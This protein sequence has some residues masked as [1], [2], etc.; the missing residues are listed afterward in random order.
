MHG[1]AVLHVAQSF[2]LRPQRDVH[3]DHWGLRVVRLELCLP[4]L[5]VT[6]HGDDADAANITTLSHA[7]ELCVAV[8]LANPVF[9]AIDHR[10]DGRDL[11]VGD[12]DHATD[13]LLMVDLPGDG[14][15]VD[16]HE[17][18]LLHRDVALGVRCLEHVVH[19]G[20]KQRPDHIDSIDLDL[21]ALLLP[22]DVHA[23]RVDQRGDA[24]VGLALGVIVLP[25]ERK[26]RV[27]QVVPV[28]DL[29]FGCSFSRH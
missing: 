23:G 12:V 21:V 15:A 27:R 3:A 7:D 1:H 28:C 13:L 14:P 16:V 2:S 17:E 18:A 19:G 4:A 10:P 9:L 5:P 20:A 8:E 26:E 24:D 29:H 6:Q 11:V 25:C 22:K